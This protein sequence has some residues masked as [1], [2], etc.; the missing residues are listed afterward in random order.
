MP[1]GTRVGMPWMHNSQQ[2][3]TQQQVYLGKEIKAACAPVWLDFLPFEARLTE[4]FTGS[5]CT[6]TH[7]RSLR[8]GCHSG[9][10]SAMRGS[11][12]THGG[13]LDMSRMC[14]SAKHCMQKTI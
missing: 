3:Q 5:L 14:F 12:I 2:A 1:P 11:F 13:C 7:T 6:N 9:M 10:T 8:R 4:F